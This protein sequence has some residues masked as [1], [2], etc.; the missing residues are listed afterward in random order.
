MLLL[1]VACSTCQ[2]Q[3]WSQSFCAQNI[4]RG[5]IGF[6]GAV[7][8][9]YW[10]RQFE[11]TLLHFLIYEK[12]IGYAIKKA[13]KKAWYLREIAESGDKGD[14]FY[15]WIGDPTITFAEVKK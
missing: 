2:W 1:G 5:A 14:P 15:A 6:Q 9:S 11:E 3:G 13:K 8:I 7:S 12:P 10:H 4:R